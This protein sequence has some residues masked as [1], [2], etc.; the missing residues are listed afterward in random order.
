MKY[1]LVIIQNNSSCAIYSYDGI[2]AALAA[3]HTELAYR[4]EGR[5]KTV[6]VILDADGYSVY[7][8][9]WQPYVAPEPEVK[10]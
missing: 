7:T 1:Y 2:D 3:Y 6:C 9:S 8:Q 10:E 5:E 4:G